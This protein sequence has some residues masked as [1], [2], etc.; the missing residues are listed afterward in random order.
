MLFI[1]ITTMSH[2]T[3]IDTKNEKICEEKLIELVK[4]LE[5]HRN[6]CMEFV[7]KEKETVER[8]WRLSIRFKIIK[9]LVFN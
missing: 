3:A 7:L 5:N 8:L 1:K 9:E 6:L 2:P 4:V